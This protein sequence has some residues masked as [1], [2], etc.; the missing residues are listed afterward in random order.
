MPAKD[1][2]NMYDIDSFHAC[3]QSQSEQSTALCCSAQ[4]SSADSAR[5]EASALS[6]AHPARPAVCSDLMC[7]HV[8][9]ADL[10]EA[11]ARR[12][13]AGSEQGEK[14]PVQPLHINKAAQRCRPV[15]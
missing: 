3:S 11:G 4:W 1:L 6:I 14:K 8:N 7:M 15:L 5:A 10:S 9:G 13:R 2:L 12:G